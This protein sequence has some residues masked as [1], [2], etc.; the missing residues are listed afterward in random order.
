[1]NWIG[2]ARRV[3]AAPV[4]ALILAAPAFGTSAHVHGEATLSVAL[5]GLTV[6]IVFD[7]PLDNLVGFEHAPRTEKQRQAL[8]GMT[9]LLVAPAHLFVLDAAA[10]CEPAGSKF[11]PPAPSS[12]PTTGAKGA[13]GE[14]H[15]EQEA[16]YTFRCKDPARLR[17][18]EVKLFGAFPRIKRIRASVA[19]AGKQTAMTLTPARRMLVWQGG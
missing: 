8:T 9:A 12:V 10:G 11:T 19:G 14:A 17:S 18:I 2:S 7:S 15:R 1:M 4:L 6:T 16:E 13:S 3:A 5:D